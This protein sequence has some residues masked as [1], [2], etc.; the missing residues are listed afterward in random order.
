MGVIHRFREEGK[1]CL[2]EGARTRPYSGE[3][4]EGTMQWLIGKPEKAPNFALRYFEIQPSKSSH[5]E[6]H[7]HDHGVIIFRGKAKVRMGE[8]EQL[9]LP[10]D[11]VYIPPNEIHQFTNVGEGTLGFFCIIPAKRGADTD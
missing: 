9:A 3:G 8:E 1:S 6:Q 11:I 2:W 4:Y 7:E 10:G 5:L